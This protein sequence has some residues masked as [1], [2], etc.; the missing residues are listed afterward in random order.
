MQSFEKVSFS[1]QKGS[2]L[3]L[4]KID[5][6]IKKGEF[7][8]IAGQSGSGKSTLMKLI[9]RLYEL[10]K[11]KILIDGYDI[12]KVELYSLRKQI[13][14]VPLDFELFESKFQKY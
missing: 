1:F 14:V 13:G 3:I 12:S 8:G 11:G 4:N 9:P 5:L 7:I 2:D 6:S 10:T